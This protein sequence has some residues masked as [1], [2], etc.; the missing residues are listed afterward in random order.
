MDPRLSVPLSSLKPEPLHSGTA[1][2]YQIVAI[3]GTDNVGLKATFKDP[4]NAD[5][6][7][8]NFGIHPINFVNYFH[9]YCI[10]LNLER[11]IG[12]WKA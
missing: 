9:E 10:I 3:V 1:H 2:H 6:F 12:V 5:W 11:Y 4:R 8:K 7:I